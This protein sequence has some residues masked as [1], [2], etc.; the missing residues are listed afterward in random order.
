[1][2][3]RCLDP[4]KRAQLLSWERHIGRPNGSSRNYTRLVMKRLRVM[5]RRRAFGYSPS[6]DVVGEL[7]KLTRASISVPTIGPSEHSF[8]NFKGFKPVKLRFSDVCLDANHLASCRGALNGISRFVLAR[9]VQTPAYAM[10]FT[11]SFAHLT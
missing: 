10:A 3:G 8:A 1:M 9:R 7:R 4:A 11:Q 5:A 2:S 6:G